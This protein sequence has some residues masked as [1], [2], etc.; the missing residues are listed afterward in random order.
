MVQMAE[1]PR[2]MLFTKNDE[3]SLHFRSASVRSSFVTSSDTRLPISRLGRVFA[4]LTSIAS[5]VQINVRRALC[6]PHGT[7]RMTIRDYMLTQIAIF[8]FFL[9]PPRIPHKSRLVRTFRERRANWEHCLEG[10]RV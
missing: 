6:F 3:A 5:A 9:L 8:L 10:Q 1:P 2:L 7:Y 4:V